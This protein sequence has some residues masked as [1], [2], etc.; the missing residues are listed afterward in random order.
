MAR[1][2][3]IAGVALIISICAMLC[4]LLVAWTARDVDLMI[5]EMA[6]EEIAGLEKRLAALEQDGCVAITDNRKL[7][8]P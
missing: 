6:N 5:V 4:C 3:T 2:V 8:T 7:E 1:R